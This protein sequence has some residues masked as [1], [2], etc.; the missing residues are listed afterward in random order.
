MGTLCS[1]L[2]GKSLQIGTDGILWMPQ[3]MTLRQS[4]ESVLMSLWYLFGDLLDYPDF[5]RL[6]RYIWHSE[7]VRSMAK[8]YL[9]VVFDPAIRVFRRQ[10]LWFD[11]LEQRLE[12]RAQIY[13]RALHHRSLPPVRS[14]R[15]KPSSEKITK[16]RFILR[17]ASINGF[18]FLI[19][20]PVQKKKWKNWKKLCAMN[21]TLLRR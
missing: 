17:C 15:M 5:I 18:F 2:G 9:Q 16:T 8:K 1:V 7:P 10:E 14:L 4:Q 19:T 12:D 21:E 20:I 13:R 11:E 6:P 3:T